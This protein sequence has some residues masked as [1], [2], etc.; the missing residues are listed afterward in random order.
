VTVGNIDRTSPD[1][2]TLTIPYTM[3]LIPKEFVMNGAEYDIA[4][5]NLSTPLTFGKNLQAIGLPPSSF[6]KDKE[7]KFPLNS[8]LVTIH[9]FGHAGKLLN[10][11]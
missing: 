11:Y 2:V 5:F 4:V 1:A 9:G 7:N 6:F 3:W 8:R 10:W